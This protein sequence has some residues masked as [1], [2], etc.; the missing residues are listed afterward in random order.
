LGGTCEVLHIGPAL[1]QGRPHPPLMI[2]SKQECIDKI[3]RF[4]KA[5]VAHFICVQV[6]PMVIDREVQAFAEEVIPAFR[7]KR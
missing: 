4:V 6:W 1:G 2:G 5:R 3:D 7:G